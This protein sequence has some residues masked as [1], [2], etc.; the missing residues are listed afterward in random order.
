M[1]E[2]N[3]AS[4]ESPKKVTLKQLL[5]LEPAVDVQTSS[6]RIYLY[7]L[8]MQ[9]LAD[10]RKLEP[11]DAVSQFRAFLPC[12]GSFE[13][14]SDASPDRVPLEGNVAAGIP[15]GEIDQL[16]E[17]Y[18][19]SS[20]FGNWRDGTEDRQ[21]LTRELGESAS[22]YLLRLL[23]AEAEEHEQS[24]KRAVEKVLGSS[25]GLF[26]QV[27]K[28]TAMLGSA[29]SAY[30]QFAKAS[31]VSPPEIRSAGMDHMHALSEQ[32]ARQARD[33]AKDR[34]E[35]MELT[36]LTGQMTAES[37]KTLKDL[38]EAATILM[39][40]LDERDRRND[41]STRTQIRI[42]LW[43]VASSAVLALVAALFAG[44]SFFQDR[45][46]NSAGDQWQG[47]ILTA[48]ESGNQRSLS[49]ESENRALREET[50]VLQGRVADLERAKAAAAA[51]AMKASSAK[52]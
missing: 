30:E 28:S 24:A 2:T 42:A 29:V 47:R 5:R 39:E 1:S 12:I 35:E 32:M 27:R 49:A 38:A 40:Q 45:E 48:I 46:S 31:R 3:P 33:R 11:A 18:A 36:R 7:P 43:S 4:G 17:A 37:A 14:E 8:R 15:D 25:R 23:K 22:A 52:R 50:K 51:K 20:E 26:E 21:P 6:G 13:I 44:F 34:A 10:F 9:D 19:Q 41:R 16:A